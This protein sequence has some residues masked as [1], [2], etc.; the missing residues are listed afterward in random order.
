MADAKS[1]GVTP[2]TKQT[3]QGQLQPAWS[4]VGLPFHLRYH[5]ALG[6]RG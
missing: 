4:V 3:I 5:A 2:S 6:P 1:E